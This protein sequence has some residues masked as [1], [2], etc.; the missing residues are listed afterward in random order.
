MFQYFYPDANAVLADPRGHL[1]ISDGRNYVELTDRSYDTIVVDPPPPIES[2]GTGVLYSREFY[3]AASRCLNPGGVMMEWI[4]YG[5]QL[6]EFMAHARTFADVF[7]EVTLA[8]GPGGY[9][10]FMLG[11]DRPVTLGPQAIRSVLE[12]PGVTDNLSTAPDSPAHDS[13]TWSQLI[14]SLFFATGD[15]VRSG[16]GPGPIITDDHPRTEYFLLRHVADPSALPMSRATL[17]AAFTRP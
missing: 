4:P 8:F 3:A 15:A 2:A 12:R 17:M 5:Q 7:P 11:S 6:D 16:I 13:A 10:V 1:V 14:P 9:G